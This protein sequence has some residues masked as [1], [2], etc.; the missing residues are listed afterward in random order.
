M[1]AI[2]AALAVSCFVG[3]AEFTSSSLS[4][5][6]QRDAAED[7]RIVNLA[8]PVAVNN[9]RR[10][11][12][13]WTVTGNDPYLMYSV[14]PVALTPNTFVFF[15]LELSCAAGITPK[16][17]SDIQLFLKL[18]DQEWSE[19]NSEVAPL[20]SESPGLLRF[21]MGR[22]GETSNATLEGLRVDFPASRTDC[23]FTPKALS[24][25]K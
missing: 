6:E 3:F 2:I 17:G 4:A 10:S 14:D 19:T 23:T 16:A 9:V 7:L 24:V 21:R 13:G 18:H 8:S 15:E 25:E 1:L 22:L 12:S 5:A 20:P 11:S